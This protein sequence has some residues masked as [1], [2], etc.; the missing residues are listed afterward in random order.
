MLRTL[1]SLLKQSMQL[2][3]DLRVLC[4]AMVVLQ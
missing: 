4:T 2:L 1:R 3:L